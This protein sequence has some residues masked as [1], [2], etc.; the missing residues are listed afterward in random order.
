MVWEAFQTWPLPQ[1]LCVAKK[2][3]HPS[4]Q[5]YAFPIGLEPNYRTFPHRFIQPFDVKRFPMRLLH[6]MVQ[7]TNLEILGL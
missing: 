3:D 6:L 1:A 5:K 7:I 4:G 2:L